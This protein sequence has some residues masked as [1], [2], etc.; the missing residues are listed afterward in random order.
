[1][2]ETEYQGNAMIENYSTN[3]SYDLQNRMYQSVVENS[4][5]QGGKY[6]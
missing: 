4:R 6:Q 5:Q 3:A 2:Y 1:M